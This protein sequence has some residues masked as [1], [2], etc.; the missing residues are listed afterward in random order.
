M[1]SI[2]G[3]SDLHHLTIH[4]VRE[5][6]VGGEYIDGVSDILARTLLERRYCGAVEFVSRVPPLN[7]LSS[8]TGILC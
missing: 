5:Q 4:R 8:Q 2:L 6:R 1:Y 7:V 3:G